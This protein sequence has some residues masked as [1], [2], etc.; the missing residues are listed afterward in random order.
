MINWKLRLGNKATLTAILM[1]A[2]SIVYTVLGMLG[3]VPSFTQSQVGDLVA[4]VVQLLT[5]LGVVVDPT[6]EGVSDSERAMGYEE[7]DKG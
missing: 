4:M 6:T 1:A 2:V 3:V 7:P 5:L